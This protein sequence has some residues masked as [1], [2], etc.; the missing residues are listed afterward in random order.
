MARD[1]GFW[2]EKRDVQIKNSDTYNDL[3]DG[4]YLDY[5]DEIPLENILQD[6]V[7]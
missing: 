5:M 3:S 7:W 4:K 2:K 1:F 6:I